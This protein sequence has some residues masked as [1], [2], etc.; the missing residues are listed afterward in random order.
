[1]KTH[2]RAGFLV[3]AGVFLGLAFFYGDAS[4]QDMPREELDEDATRLLLP[5]MNP[6][7]GKKIFLDKG[8]IVCHKINGIGG[9]DGP[10][11]DHLVSIGTICP[12]SFAAK[13]WNHAPGMIATQEDMLGEQVYFTGQELADIISFVHDKETQNSVSD[14]DVSEKIRRIMAE[15]EADEEGEEEGGE[16]E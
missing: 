9:E 3:I 10:K 4:A 12:F 2:L 11:M 14:K 5:M 8:C 7:R 15:L 6:V 13:M 16:G 1:M